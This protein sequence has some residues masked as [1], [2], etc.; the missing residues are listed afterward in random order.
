VAHIQEGNQL[1]PI[2]RAQLWMLAGLT[3]GPVSKTSR[4]HQQFTFRRY[5]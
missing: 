3:A 4:G 1:A 2:K 5:S